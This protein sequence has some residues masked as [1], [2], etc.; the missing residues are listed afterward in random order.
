M[1]GGPTEQQ[2]PPARQASMSAGVGAAEPASALIPRWLYTGGAWSWRLIA[3][4]VVAFYLLRF[5][6][7]IELVVLPFL[8]AMVFTALLRP[9]SQ[10]LQQHGS[11]RLL[12]TWATFLLALVVVLGVGT[13]VVYRS[14]AEWHILVSDLT[15]TTDKLRNWLS[16]GPFHLKDTDLKDLQKKLLDTL[17]Q[18]RGA[19]VRPDGPVAGEKQHRHDQ[20]RK[21]RTLHR[22]LPLS[23]AEPQKG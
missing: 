11:S 19:V 3:I 6:L 21:E 8:M 13:L 22:E 7:K 20:N 16:T 10:K 5:V 1:A 2:K 14:I 23:N 17:N 18:H 9:M 4:G 15:D 12:A